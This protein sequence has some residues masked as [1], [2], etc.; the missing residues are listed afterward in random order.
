MQWFENAKQGIRRSRAFIALLS[1]GGRWQTAIVCALPLLRSLV[2]TAIIITTGVLVDSVPEAIANGLESPAGQQALQALAAVAIAFLLH[3]LLEALSMYTARAA[4]T[5][6]AITVHDAVAA[7]ALSPGGIAALEDPDIAAE[8]ATVEEYDRAGT[9]RNAVFQLGQFVSQR[10][11]GIAAFVILLGFHWW[12]PFVLLLGWRL[13]NRSV[14]QW[15]EKGIALGHLMSGTGLR[16]AQYYRSLAVEAPAAKEVRI[17]GLGDWIVDQYADAWRTAMSEIWQGRKAS[18]PGVAL[19]ATALAAAHGIV[20]GYLGWTALRGE[21]SLAELVI[22]GQAVLATILLGPLGDFQW[23]A[24]RI[25]AAADKVVELE[26]KLS[27]HHPALE[28][29]PRLLTAGASQADSERAG[30]VTVRLE[31]V[32]F[33]YRGRPKPT[34]DG[35][36]LTIPAGQS[37]AI[38]G[39]NGVGKTTLIK[40]LCGLYESDAG[41]IEIDQASPLQARHRI[42]V[43]FQD[44]V[45]YELS[46]RANV[47]FGN[48][49][50][51][52]DTDQLEEAL[53]DAGGEKLLATLPAGWDTVLARGYENGVDLS[54]GQWQKVALAR[55]FT[56][57][58]GGAGLLILDEPTANLDVRAESEL[59]NRFLEITKDLTT[60][61]VSHRLSSVR[62]AD[63]IVVVADGRIVEDGSHDELMRLGGRY[64]TMYTLQAERFAA[65]EGRD[66]KSDDASEVHRVA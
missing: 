35:L 34:L 15:V 13:V 66:E 21:V 51:A 62:H 7:A 50:L 8:F 20:V 33:T 36:D 27:G 37:L 29:G 44:F 28:A 43:I 47:G 18:L 11:Q 65:T 52:K 38:V 55:A 54:G 58:R 26:D 48:L 14:V 53:R 42:G 45:R 41:T 46:L 40:L 5:R 39:E 49:H 4:G 31:G 61:L 25:L 9:Y 6:Y 17:F 63:R 32:G 57:I 12:A 10:L 64:A 19:S 3:G 24:G 1:R 22:F 56:A 59:F 2:P 23:Q 30:P 60:I 16:R